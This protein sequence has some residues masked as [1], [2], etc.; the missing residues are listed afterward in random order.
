MQ[1]ST[2]Q[3]LETYKLADD[4]RRLFLFLEYRD[5]RELFTEIETGD[6][7]F[8][9]RFSESRKRTTWLNRLKRLTAMKWSP[10]CSPQTPPGQ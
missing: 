9:S 10:H 4:E 8:E 7:S 3:I 5:L 2:D 1:P 6:L